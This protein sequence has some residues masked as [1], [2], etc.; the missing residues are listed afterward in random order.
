MHAVSN[1]YDNL[2]WKDYLNVTNVIIVLLFIIQLYIEKEF[3]SPE[4]RSTMNDFRYIFKFFAH[5]RTSFWIIT[6]FK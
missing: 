4:V 3:G 5:T 6:H 2:M 1:K